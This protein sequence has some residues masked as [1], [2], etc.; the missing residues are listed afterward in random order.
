MIGEASSRVPVLIVLMKG[1][2]WARPGEEETSGSLLCE[3]FY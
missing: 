3:D 2:S 1:I